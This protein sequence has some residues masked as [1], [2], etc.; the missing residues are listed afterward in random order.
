MS[1]N[2]TVELDSTSNSI[3]NILLFIKQDFLVYLPLLLIIL[4]IIGFIGNAF[5]FLQSTLRY[6]T[7]CIYLLCGSLVDAINLLINLLSNYIHD[8]DN[9]LTLVTDRFLC[10]LRLFGLV[11]LPQF[12]MNLLTL[13]LIDRYACTCS[14]ASSIRQIRRIIIAPWLIIITAIISAALSSF[15]PLLHDI[16]PG[17]G[18]TSINPYLNGLLY[19]LLHGF[20][21]PIVML[22]FVSLTYRNVQE[23]RR[24]A[25]DISINISF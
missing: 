22:T 20:V 13:S 3:V 24:R 7:C 5:T 19:I 6:N 25:V 18:C 8:T 14:L 17:F 11:F 21:T 12:S 2:K 16:V 23:S 10:K 9:I 15:A 1:P 4:G